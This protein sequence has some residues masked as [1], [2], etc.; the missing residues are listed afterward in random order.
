MFRKSFNR[1]QLASRLIYTGFHTRFLSTVVASRAA[2]SRSVFRALAGGGILGAASLYALH[3]PVS[4]ETEVPQFVQ[5]ETKV[6]PFP[7]TIERSGDKF[8][9]LGAGVRS[10]SFLSL[11]VYAV[12]IYIAAKDIPRLSSVINVE[13]LH[14]QDLEMALLDPDSGSLI[15]HK[16]LNSGISL[17][18][19]IVP[20][21]NT[22]FSHLKDGFVRTIMAHPRF[23]TE[24]NTEQVGEGI[25]QLKRIFSRKRSVPKN[26][27]L[28]LTR[29]GR[30]V[31]TVTYY[32]GD[33]EA[34]ADQ[35]PLGV[36][37]EPLVSELL[38]MQYLSGKK[39]SSESARKT[40]VNGLVKLA[41]Q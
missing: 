14:A 17:D 5:P 12:G 36:V 26:K 21:R 29:D 37:T 1:F 24:G 10:V 34:A 20:V 15:M 22:D 41:T 16:L 6:K 23:K 31:L 18:L 3:Q 2:P 28:H 40:S 30:G 33:S 9:L 4:L 11:H 27:I 39:P 25:N 19:R 32:N 35:E 38:F 8:Q 13:K 7:V